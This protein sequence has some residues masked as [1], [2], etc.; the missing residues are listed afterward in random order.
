MNA[1][2]LS[3]TPIAIEGLNGLQ[4][5]FQID[6]PSTSSHHHNHHHHHHHHHYHHYYNNNHHHHHHHHQFRIC[7]RLQRIVLSK[8]MNY[9]H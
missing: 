7:R 4:V 3:R 9:S 8:L 2:F 6:A 1:I 5:V